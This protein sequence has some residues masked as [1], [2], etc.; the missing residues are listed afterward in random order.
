[1]RCTRGDSEGGETQA[2]VQG[3]SRTCQLPCDLV[4]VTRHAID[5]RARDA[6]G[7]PTPTGVEVRTQFLPFCFA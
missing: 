2:P 5:E 1:M 3:I 4:N 6:I 7:Y